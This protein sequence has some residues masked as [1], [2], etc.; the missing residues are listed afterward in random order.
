MSGIIG[1]SPNMKSG[2]MNGIEGPGPSWN[3]YVASDYTHVANAV[4]AFNTKT[5]SGVNAFSSPDA[6]YNTSTYSYTVPVSGTYWVSCQ[7]LWGDISSGTTMID[8]INIYTSKGE[9]S[10][11]HRRC[12]FVEDH[13]GDA[14]YFGDSTSFVTQLVAGQEIWVKG[15]KG[16]TVHANPQ[17][18]LFCGHLVSL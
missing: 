17:Y 3:V 10:I 5:G 6:S 1:F 8:S 4:I 14:G 11:G 16:E 2:F 13:T 7:V 18:T 12:F 15:T 9:G